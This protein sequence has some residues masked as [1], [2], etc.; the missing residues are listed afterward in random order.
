MTKVSSK[1]RSLAT[2]ILE[3]REKLRQPAGASAW[4]VPPLAQPGV[5]AL[6]RSETP[7]LPQNA[8]RPLNLQEPEPQQAHADPD[9][10]PGDSR[11]IPALQ[12]AHLQTW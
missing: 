7:T 8:T 2:G 1:P 9:S 11:V 10:I 6:S 4:A 5:T 3:A 12:L